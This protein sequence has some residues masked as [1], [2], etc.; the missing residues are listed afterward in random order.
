MASVAGAPFASVGA[1][2]ASA[3]AVDSTGVSP[4]LCSTETF[5]CNAGIEIISAENMK[6]HAAI[7]VIFART[8]A[9]PRGPKAAFEILLVNSA[10]ASVLP[11][12]SS[13]VP[14][15]TMQD[16]KNKGNKILCVLLEGI[17]NA[18]WDCEISPDDVKRALSFYRQ[19]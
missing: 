4:T 8:E 10:P 18:K 16:K 11:G 1:T 5:P 3:G 9:V 12:C 15:R 6:T 13:T 7:I 19:N 14:M 17:G 2:L